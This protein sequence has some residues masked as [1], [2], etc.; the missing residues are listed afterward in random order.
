L[1][2]RTEQDRT[3]L[4]R[5]ERRFYHAVF[6]A[7]NL[8][9]CCGVGLPENIFHN[10]GRAYGRLRILGE[11][12]KFRT[13]FRELSEGEGGPMR[14]R[15]QTVSSVLVLVS[16][17]LIGLYTVSSKPRFEMFHAVDVVQLIASGMCFGAALSMLVM[18]FR[19]RSN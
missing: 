4:I 2:V 15:S 18:F 11:E 16:V 12:G 14:N 3:V 5:H 10:F 6:D 19:G 13:S 9:V 8:S 17:G 1:F 7:C